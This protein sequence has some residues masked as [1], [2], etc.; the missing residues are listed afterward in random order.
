MREIENKT[1]RI[2]PFQKYGRQNIAIANTYDRWNMAIRNMNVNKAVYKNIK[3]KK[4]IKN[5]Y[6][7][8]PDKVCFF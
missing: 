2:Q 6:N 3:L 5:I 7:R 8:Q 4:S 1:I